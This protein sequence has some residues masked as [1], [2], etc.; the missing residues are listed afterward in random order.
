[1][2]GIDNPDDIAF[3]GDSAE[4]FA[5]AVV[6]CMREPALAQTK[7]R[8]ALMHIRRRYSRSAFIEAFQGAIPEL[9][10]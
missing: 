4:E 6:A 7:A 2:Q 5:E 3:V 8:S 1:M 9:S 10:L